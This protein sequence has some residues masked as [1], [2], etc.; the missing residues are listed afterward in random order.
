MSPHMRMALKMYENVGSASVELEDNDQH[1]M[2]EVLLGG[3][4]QRVGEAMAAVSLKDYEKKSEV[5]T[6]AQKI[7]FGLRKTLDFE[8]GGEL[9]V[10]LDSLYD[11]CLRTLT[12]AHA[13]ND[14]SLFQEVRD[15][16]QDLL[17]AWSKIGK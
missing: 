16:F 3:V 13:Y 17:D 14:V 4:Q 10:N 1:K 2:V 5:V 6:K 8:S 12:R 15:I 11:Y 7:I 9:A